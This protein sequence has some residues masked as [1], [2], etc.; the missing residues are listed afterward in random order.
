MGWHFGGSWAAEAPLPQE[1][2]VERSH[3]PEIR[4]APLHPSGCGL[5]QEP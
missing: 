4:G 1:Q 3:H 5:S 2:A